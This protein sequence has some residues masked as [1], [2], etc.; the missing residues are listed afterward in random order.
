METAE[1]TA[2]DDEAS[3]IVSDEGNTQE[4]EVQ[5]QEPAQEAGGTPDLS[6]QL[7]ALSQEVT[8][9]R[10]SL[11][12]ESEQET[13]LYAQLARQAGQD[14]EGTAQGDAQAQGQPGAGYDD[15]FDAII[16]ER[17]AEATYPIFAQMEQDR[18]RAQ[19][20]DVAER[21]PELLDRSV[22]DTIT[23]R[24]EAIAERYGNDMILTDPELVEAL[25]IA[26]KA[27]QTSASEVPAEQAV[28][29][30]ARLES[31][32]GASATE[33]PLT[34]EDQIKQGVLGIR[35]GGDLFT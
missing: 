14:D 18:R 26:E 33:A 10:G 17:V 8:A 35:G 32:R 23:D 1:A 20:E 21:H 19:L 3:Q 28:N 9:L 7:A 15:P 25:L 29:Q 16:R 34:P 6:E 31:A 11:N 13:D 12:P 27:A 24:L 2:T 5:A 4:P 30:G 22:Q